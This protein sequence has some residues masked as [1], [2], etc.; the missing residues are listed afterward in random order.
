M[1]T[2]DFFTDWK[3]A[4]ARALSVVVGSVAG[5]K[6]TVTMPKVTLDG[7]ETGDRNGA[8]TRDIPFRAAC[9]DAGNDEVQ[10]K[11]E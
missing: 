7:V 3:N 4:T 2:Y 10:L 11:F 6:L 1:A 5:N 8:V 9:T